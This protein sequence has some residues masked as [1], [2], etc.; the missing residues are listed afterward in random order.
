[1]RA[2][3][4][5]GDRVLPLLNLLILAVLALPIVAIVAIVMAVRTRTRLEALERRFAW[6][7]RRLDERPPVT[8]A[9]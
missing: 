6:F 5:E 9:P 1:M 3:F 7:E 4:A 8:Q 2:K